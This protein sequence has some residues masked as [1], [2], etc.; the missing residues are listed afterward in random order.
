MFVQPLFQLVQHQNNRI[1]AGH[2]LVFDDRLRPDVAHLDHTRHLQPACGN[3]CR[4]CCKD[5]RCRG[6]DDV[7]FLSIFDEFL[8]CLL[9]SQWKFQHIINSGQTVAGIIPCFQEGIRHTVHRF[10]FVKRS[11]ADHIDIGIVDLTG[12]K[13]ADLVS[14]LMQIL[15]KIVVA[16]QST[17]RRWNCIMID[18]PNPHKSPLPFFS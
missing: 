3:Q 4:A 13:D 6:V 10:F 1:F 5:G 8:Y 17:H 16:H 9:N 18:D 12:G 7:R 14:H 11:V 15:G 2:S